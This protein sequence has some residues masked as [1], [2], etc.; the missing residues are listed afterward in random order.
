MPKGISKRFILGGL[1]AVVALIAVAFTWFFLYGPGVW[2]DNISNRDLSDTTVDAGLPREANGQSA[3]L[4]SAFHGL[5][6]LPR[7]SNVICRG[8]EGN[9]GMPV[10]FST[11]IDISTMQAGDFRV[12]T[13]SGAIGTMHCASVLPATDPGELRTVLL[14][15]QLGPA[16]SD[17]PVRV[18]IIGH[19]HSID[20]T[21]DFRGASAPVIPLEDGPSIT[22]A[23][24]VDDWTQVGTL[25]PRRVRGSLCPTK[26]IVQAVRVTWEGGVTLE[27]GTEPGEAERDLYT[28]TVTAADGTRRDINPAALANLGDGD[29]NHV[30]CMDTSDMPVS[31]SFP[32]SVL[33]DP[34][35]DLNPATRA[36]VSTLR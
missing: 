5:D 21:I 3:E 19:L 33:T 6:A 26:G 20:G 18:D 11:E 7:V 16:D 25:G 12:T 27:D 23:E 10:I 17:P 32:A 4:L 14:I 1:G 31:V 29:N 2:T 36:D 28:I 35:G 22:L 9:T 24:V 30:L 13:Q 15:G 34:N 8:S